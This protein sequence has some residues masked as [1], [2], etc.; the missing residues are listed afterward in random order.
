MK[1]WTPITLAVLAILAAAPS[2]AQNA[3]DEPLEDMDA[4][5]AAAAAPTLGTQG[6]TTPEGVADGLPDGVKLDGTP[7][8]NTSSTP[9]DNALSTSGETITIPRDVW[10]QLQRDVAELKASRAGA[11]VETV[12]PETSAPAS[13]NYLTLPDISLVLQAKGLLSNDKRD[14]ERNRVGFSEGELTIQGYVYPNVRADAFIVGAPAEDEFG[15]EEAFLTFEGVAKGLNV[16]VGRKFAPF[17]RT[18]ELHN[19]SWMYPRQL[20]PIRNLVAEEA[21][22]GDGVN[23]H[24]LFPTGGKLFLRGSLGLFNGEGTETG[25]NISDPSDP[26]FGGLPGGP[27]S[28]FN[29]RFYNARLWGGLPLGKDGELELGVSHARGKSSILDDGANQFDGRVQLNGVDLSYRK[30]MDNGR[31]LSLRGEYFQ[32]KPNNLP[33]AKSSGY[34]GLASLKLDPRNDIGLLYEKIRFPKRAWPERKR[35]LVPLHQ[36][37]HRA[38]LCALDGHARRTRWRFL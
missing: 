30:F 23:L 27:G 25:V 5:A 13:R 19:H 9:S 21:L 16:N 29:S 32:Y 4:P 11:T 22:V 12:N 33:T 36:A 3:E 38:V 15:F 28:G 2:W 24:Y 14:E 37:V 18:G 7:P 26:F 6:T 10:E 8:S 35:F 1:K 31:R 34:Y 20:L 17:G